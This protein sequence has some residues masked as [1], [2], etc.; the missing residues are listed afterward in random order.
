[1]KTALITGGSRGIG[2]ALVEEFARAGYRV[3][4]TYQSNQ[5]AA[6]E[7]TATLAAEGLAVSPFACDV[8]EFA[9]VESMVAQ[10]EETIGPVDVLVNNAGVR[11]DGAFFRMSPEAWGDTIA[12][13]LTGV[14][15]VCRAAVPVMMRRGGVII[16]MT[17]AAGLMGIPGQ[18]N[19]CASKAGIIGLTKALAKELAR[20]DVRVNAIAPGYIDTGMTEE[21][22]EKALKKLLQQAPM[23]RAGSAA[24]VARLALYLASDD[25]S[26]MTGQVISMDGGLV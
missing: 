11:R 10:V 22:S 19:Y 9:V 13:N 7:L 21:F 20:L 25:A 5:E 26:Y 14:F 18:A 3:A 6:D 12:T 17:S 8:R 2:R 15:N 23:G 16:N 4:F 1:M 24:E